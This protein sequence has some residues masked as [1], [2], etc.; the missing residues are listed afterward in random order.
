MKKLRALWASLMGDTDRRV[1]LGRI[2]GFVLIVI[3]F[4]AI[5]KAW[6]GA[7]SQTLLPAMFPYLLSGGFLG[8]G[9]V[10]TGAMLIFLATLRAERQLLSDRYE[11]MATL[12]SRNLARMAVSAN[13]AAASGETVV[14]G[15]TAY[16]RQ[17]C[18]VLQGKED[19]LPIPL[20]QAVAEGLAACRVCDPPPPPEEKSEETPSGAATSEDDAPEEKGDKAPTSASGTRSP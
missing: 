8:L 14:A 5:A 2:M 1:R 17:G 13:G 6:D 10:I 18:R 19:L 12:L 15:Q 7:A 20:E 4:V 16:H 3:G 9:L 11:Q